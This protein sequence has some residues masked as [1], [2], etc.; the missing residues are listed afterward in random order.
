MELCMLADVSQC[1]DLSEFIPAATKIYF[2]FKNSVV[3]TFDYSDIIMD[4]MAS[5]ITGTSIVYSNF[6][7]GA[8]QRK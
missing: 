2:A 6:C 8:D 3:P 4:A 1:L 5:Q 7:S